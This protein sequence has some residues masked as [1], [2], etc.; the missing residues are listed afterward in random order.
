MALAYSAKDNLCIRV[1]FAAVSGKVVEQSDAWGAVSAA[2][3]YT[4]RDWYSMFFVAPF[5]THSTLAT[6]S[7]TI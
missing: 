5:P 4:E 7:D 6:S 2:V 1:G 3:T